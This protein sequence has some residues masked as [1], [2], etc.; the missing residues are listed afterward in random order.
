MGELVVLPYSVEL[1]SCYYMSRYSS[2][3]IEIKVIGSNGN[4]DKVILLDSLYMTST[5]NI[6]SS[7]CIPQLRERICKYVVCKY[8][9][10]SNREDKATL[11][12]LI[13][14]NI[15][16]PSSFETFVSK[17]ETSLC[18]QCNERKLIEG[19]YYTNNM[20]SCIQC[21]CRYMGITL[22]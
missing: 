16:I 2:P 8:F 18:S 10:S 20:V 17:I 12:K 11:H 9:D 5:C 14:D 6:T 3:F 19:F 4:L 13:Y 7:T 1:L 22:P 15:T 21:K